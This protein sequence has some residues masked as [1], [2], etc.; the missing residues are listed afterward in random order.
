MIMRPGKTEPAAT[1]SPLANPHHML[2]LAHV[3]L[4][5][6]IAPVRVVG[7]WPA[8]GAVRRPRRQNRRHPFHPFPK[9]HVVVPFVPDLKR[10]NSARD[11]VPGQLLKVR[12]PNRVDR[13]VGLEITASPIE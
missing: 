6:G 3:F 10:M 4:N 11:L 5:L 12:H 8:A 2:G 7:S 13:P 9:A 1:I